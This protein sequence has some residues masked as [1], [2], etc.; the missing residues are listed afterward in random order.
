MRLVPANTFLVSLST[1]NT[2]SLVLHACTKVVTDLILLHY[3]SLHENRQGFSCIQWSIGA[4]VVRGI[5][6]S[7]LVLRALN[8]FAANLCSGSITV[9]K[10]VMA[11]APTHSNNSFLFLPPS[12]NLFAGSSKYAILSFL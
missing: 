12:I 3:L 10:L 1:H 6:D 11:S 9:T 7:S 2:K 4:V 8:V 5:V